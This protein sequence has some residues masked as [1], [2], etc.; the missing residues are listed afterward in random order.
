MPDSSLPP[1]GNGACSEEAAS[2]AFTLT[3]IAGD[4][5]SCKGTGNLAARTYTISSLGAK[6]A[7]GFFTYQSLD[8]AIFTNT[9]KT[10]SL[11]V[12]KTVV[13][14]D[15]GDTFNFI[16]TLGETVV[17]KD[18]YTV[19]PGVHLG[20]FGKVFT[21]SLANGGSQ[22]LTGLPAGATYTVEERRIR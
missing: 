2:D 8:T 11:T 1:C 20:P 9:R 4:G 10:G 5:D 22:T 6:D 3:G 12:S 19:P 16:V 7:K 15:A 17:D 18:H 21:F 13:D 14:G